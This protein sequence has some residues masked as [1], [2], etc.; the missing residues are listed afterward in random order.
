VSTFFL[1]NQKQN[2][3][4][5]RQKI[6]ISPMDPHNKIAYFCNVMSIDMTLQ[7]WAIF[8]LGVYGEISHFLSDPTEIVFLVI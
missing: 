6:R 1:Y 2:F 5:I 3:S 7:K 4:L 8:I